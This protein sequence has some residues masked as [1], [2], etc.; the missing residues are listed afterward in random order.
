M[1][2]KVPYGIFGF[3]CGMVFVV[4]I[5]MPILQFITGKQQNP[6]PGLYFFLI[7]VVMG[8][9]GIFLGLKV[10]KFMNDRSV[11][12]II[13]N[14]KNFI[15]KYLSF[16]ATADRK[17]EG[18]YVIYTTSQSL[19]WGKIIIVMLASYLIIRYIPKPYGESLSW[20]VLVLF[21]MT[22]IPRGRDKTR[23]VSKKIVTNAQGKKEIWYEMPK[24]V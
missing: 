3:F 23:A 13:P 18:N 2:Q 16:F 15:T 17:I 6:I 5:I 1:R 11:P 20:V 4:F 14:D 24:N 22:E 12:D 8:I 7:I 19:T 10:D 21:F 9:V